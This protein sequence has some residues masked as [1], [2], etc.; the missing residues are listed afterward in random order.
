METEQHASLV[1]DL[2]V[3][4]VLMQNKNLLAGYQK[5]IEPL[6]V[7]IS[8]E[9]RLKLAAEFR[10]RDVYGDEVHS[11]DGLADYLDPP[12]GGS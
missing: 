9:D 3:E 4:Y 11:L 8:P 2:P 10:G 6:L 5:Y 7:G 12:V 1:R